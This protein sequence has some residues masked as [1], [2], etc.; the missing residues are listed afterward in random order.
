MYLTAQPLTSPKTETV[1]SASVYQER[2]TIAGE[3]LIFVSQ[4][5]NYADSNW[6]IRENGLSIIKTFTIRKFEMAICPKEL[7]PINIWV[8]IHVLFKVHVGMILRCRF[9]NT[10]KQINFNHNLYIIY[11]GKLVFKNKLHLKQFHDKIK[12]LHIFL[13]TAP[14]C[15]WSHQATITTMPPSARNLRL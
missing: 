7:T 13:K 14:T 1:V 2:A 12:K 10:N 15:Y 6:L 3:G 8:F 11:I 5:H 4:V 9:H